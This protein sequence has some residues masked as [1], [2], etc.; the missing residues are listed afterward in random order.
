MSRE[1][2]HPHWGNPPWT[3]HF[4]PSRA[5]MPRE[6]DFAVVGAGFSGL[7][8]AASLC[9]LAPDKTVVVFESVSIGAGAS[10]HT[11]GMVLAETAA[12]DLPGLGDVLG[13]FSSILKDFDVECD[14]AL[15]GVFEIGR[16]SGLSD[17]PIAWSDSGLV[18]AVKN[19]PGGMVD[20]GK[21]VSGLARAAE[22]NGARIFENLTVDEI[23][24][25][26]VP[27]LRYS[28]GELR[29]RK[30]LLATNSMSLEMSDLAQRGQPKFT[31]AVATEPLSAEQW[32]GLGL[33]SH[34]P[35]YT[36]DFPYLWGR[37]LST[38][39]CVFGCGLVPVENWREFENLD[40][41]TGQPAELISRLEC[42]VRGLHPVMENVRFANRW[43]GP[44]LIANEWRPVFERHPRSADAIVLGAFSGHGVAQ[45]VYLGRWAAEAL[46]GRKSLPDW[47]AREESA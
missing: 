13:G 35:F 41:D 44:I 30:V 11:G 45:S 22:K 18:R 46:C 19:V 38:G 42:R 25:G 43:G 24:F 8:A 2:S 31:L 7:S 3:L 36:V 37:M 27:W 9:Q 15:P 28:G 17:S 5:A 40:I 34:K 10:G 47:N 33:N 32:N 20:P 6:A 26:D 12:G 16:K 14:L 21:M 23:E 29:A 1:V 4:Q 39:G